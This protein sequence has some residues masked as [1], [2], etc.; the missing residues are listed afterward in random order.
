MATLSK[1]NILDQQ[2]AAPSLS[3]CGFIN[4]VVNNPTMEK[5]YHIINS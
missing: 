4:S 5:L 3:K 2:F 1:A